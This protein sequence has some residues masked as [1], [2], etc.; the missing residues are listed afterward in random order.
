METNQNTQVNNQKKK[1]GLGRGL[2][3][4]LGE[5]ENTKA[6]LQT[7][8]Q[9]S[10]V[11]SEVEKIPDHLR[12]I[13]MDVTQ[14]H[15]N[16][17][18]PRRVF[19][20]E[21]LKELAAS[22]K[23]KGIISPILVR[24]TKDKTNFEIIAGERRWRAAQLA[25]L[26]EVPVIIKDTDDKT[27]LEIALIENIQR[28]DLSPLEEAEAYQRLAN[29]HNMTQSEIAQ[30]VG[31]ERAT[32]ANAIRLLELPNEIKEML[33]ANSLSVGHAK[34]LLSMPNTAEQL[35]VA[36]EVVTK[37]LSVRATEKLV[38]QKLLP[39]KLLEI[40]EPNSDEGIQRIVSR[41]GEDLQKFLGTKVQIDYKEQKGKL[42]LHFYSDEEL[43]RLV[44]KLKRPNL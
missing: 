4:L 39:A 26:S 9:E 42:T 1:S 37:K 43:N 34:V 38:A 25:G 2:G 36:K 18:Q 24:R 30:K 16:P 14:L 22:I 17:S 31:K 10:S 23:E 11:A 8:S 28:A 21:K 15:G 32:V 27:T 5:I 7:S 41:V 20:A 29:E 13:L 33:K 40:G 6:A 19:D 44:D 12:V 3:S 35:T